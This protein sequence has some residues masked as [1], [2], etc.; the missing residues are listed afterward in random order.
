MP[1]DNAS[2]GRVGL[3][4]L[5]DVTMTAAHQAL[6]DRAAHASAG[7]AHWRQRKRVEVR[8]MLALSQITPRNR[9]RVLDL[10]MTEQ[11][12]LLVH[13]SV[14]VP[15]M[16]PSDNRLV[17]FHDA[18]LAMRYPQEVMTEDLPGTSF[19]QVR[20][21]RWLWH[22]NAHHEYGVLCLGMKLPRNIPLTEITWLCFA[23]LAM[24]TWNFDE[25]DA[26]GVI[27]VKAARYWALNRQR[28]PLTR[29]GLLE[30][31]PL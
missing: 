7:P 10:K 20:Q 8:D 28:L 24:Q 11:V 29:T 21:P 27:N 5:A 30:D 26:A 9:L 19:V 6:L 23:A 2:N 25:R 4:N 18:L 3:N 1:T 12:E 22:A 13:M 14:T 15:C 16:A 17:V 31:R